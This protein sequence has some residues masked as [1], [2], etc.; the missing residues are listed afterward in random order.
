MM[1]RDVPKKTVIIANPLDSTAKFEGGKLVENHP[2]LNLG[3]EHINT[4]RNVYDLSTV[5]PE[6]SMTEEQWTQLLKTIIYI[7]PEGTID[8]MWEYAKLKP[9]RKRAW[10]DAMNEKNKQHTAEHT[11]N[12]KAASS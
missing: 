1:L 7:M 6:T 2:P 12:M 3:K 8:D 10:N 5:L 11:A 4:N 9:A